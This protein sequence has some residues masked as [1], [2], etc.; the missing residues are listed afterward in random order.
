VRPDPPPVP[1]WPGPLLAVVDV[2][3]IFV[4][5]SSEWSA[6]RFHEIVEPLRRL[7]AGFHPDRVIFTRFVPPAA[8]AGAWADYYERFPFARQAPDSPDYRIAAEFAGAA[9]ETL[10]A[11]TFG[12][13]GRRLADSVGPGGTLVLAGVA[14]ECCVLATALAAADAGARVRVAADACAGGSDALHR[15]ALD[16]MRSY[17]PLIEVLAVSSL[18]PA[19][20]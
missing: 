15:Q 3:Q 10:D 17:E 14:T 19:A 1:P 8:P 5:P 4:D 20:G 6:H 13:W 12:K 9:G 7:L 11:T 2:Q 16:V 18:T